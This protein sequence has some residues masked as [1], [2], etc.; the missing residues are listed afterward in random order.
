MNIP[1]HISVASHTR[2]HM[3]DLADQL[4]RLKQDVRLY[5]GYP[6]WKIQSGLRAFAT[7]HPLLTL[8]QAGL[9][10]I[11]FQDKRTRIA[12][13]V[14]R[15]FGH[16][17]GQVIKR[18][19]ILDVI[20]GCGL[21]GGR[22]IQQEDGAW[23]CNRGSSHILFQKTNLEE[24]HTR[25]GAP[26]PY[27]SQRGIERELTEY[28]EADAIAVPSEFAKRT[29][30]EQGIQPEKIFKLPYGVD[31]SLFAPKPKQDSKFRVLFVG[32]FSIRK[33][34]G[35]L[36]EAMKPLVE[37]GHAELW[38][39]GKPEPAANKILARYKD[40][41]TDMGAHPRKHLA[42]LYSQGSVLVLPSVEEGLALVQIQAMA[43]GVPVIATYNTGAE[44]LF[45]DGK[46]GF[47]VP[48]REPIAIKE[49][50][51]RLICNP[52]LQ[53]GMA[54]AALNRVKFMGG[55]D[56]YGK[57]CLAMYRKVLSCKWGHT[58]C[59]RAHIDPGPKIPNS[60]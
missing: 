48:P 58:D 25:W 24:E 37:K 1:L 14:L 33:G 47:I 32:S 53:R 46:E 60:N 23:V 39:I 4:V 30:I 28:H 5:T 50:I 19:D 57:K 12:D 34:I 29:F 52:E 43:C 11:G 7:T 20:S 21:E 13:F 59:C 36:F 51:E 31:L 8:V 2:F 40:I 55:W 38:L 17:L 18:C 41:F 10:R 44:D 56:T 54:K 3:F 22:W 26:L 16:W 45:E 27:F 49:L 35:Y 42:D 6:R 15:D 9:Q